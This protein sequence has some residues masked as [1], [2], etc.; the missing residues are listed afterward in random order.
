MSGKGIKDLCVEGHFGAGRSHE[1]YVIVVLFKKHGLV[2]FVDPV[3]I[4]PDAYIDQF[5]REEK[6]RY[7]NYQIYQ[8]SPYQN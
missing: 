2:F 6:S 4:F 3:L 5:T 7:K 8:C 1:Q